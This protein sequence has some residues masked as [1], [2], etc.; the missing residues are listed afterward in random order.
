MMECEVTEGCHRKRL[1]FDRT[2]GPLIHKR[3]Q[4]KVQE[5]STASSFAA[6]LTSLSTSTMP[7]RGVGRSWQEATRQ[8]DLSLSRLF[9]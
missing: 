5:V 7:F 1:T 2:H 9:L 8:K 3:Q 6:V 4:Q